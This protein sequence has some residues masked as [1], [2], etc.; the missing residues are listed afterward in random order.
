MVKALPCRLQNDSPPQSLNGTSLDKCEYPM[1]TQDGLIEPS[2]HCVH[3]NNNIIQLAKVS[4]EMNY[5]NLNKILEDECDVIANELQ[6]AQEVLV[7]NSVHRN[8]NH[9]DPSA[10]YA[11]ESDANSSYAN[12]INSNNNHKLSSAL[13]HITPTITTNNNSVNCADKSIG[14]TPNQKTINNLSSNNTDT[15]TA[16]A[17]ALFAGNGNTPMNNNELNGISIVNSG[18]NNTN[19]HMNAANKNTFANCS[20]NNAVHGK[21][22]S[23]NEAISFTHFIFLFGFFSIF[24]ID[25]T[26]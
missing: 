25:I 14:S 19:S 4:G 23:Q 12:T 21:Q 17:S 18:D 11:S 24:H 16:A 9:I 13:I 2:D 10:Y 1:D 26:I 7:A 3:D 15:S 20:S 5:V 8:S 22:R 6:G